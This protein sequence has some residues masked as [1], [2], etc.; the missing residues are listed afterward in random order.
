MGGDITYTYVS[1]NDYEVTLIIY[2]DC[3]GISVSTSPS[4]TFESASCG[5]NFNFN[6]PFI[7]INDVSQ[8]C[9]G[10]TTTCNGG[11]LPGV[12]QYVF[13]G[14]VTLT[15]CA[16]WI[17]HWNNG[18][19]NANITNLVSPST[20][21]L[22]IQTTLNNIVG[23]N[24]NSPQ[25]FN[26]PTPYLCVNNLAILSHGATDA[27]GDS[28]YYLMAQP[29]TTPGPPGVLIPYTA[30]HTVLQPVITTSGLTL[31]AETGQ[32]CF[33]PS[34]GQNV[35]ISVLIKEYRNGSLIGSLI[36]EMQ[37]KIDPGC[38]NSPPSTSGTPTCNGA[39][40]TPDPLTT[41]PTV[42][43]VDDNSLAMCPNTNVCFD[44]QFSDLDGDNILVTSNVL[45]A[46]PGAT[47]NVINNNTQNPIARVCWT[48]TQLDSGL[49]VLTILALDDGC[50][51]SV[52]Q[53]F[54]FDITVFDQPYAGLDETICENET[55]QLNATG[56][57]G[58]TWYYDDGIG[59]NLVP[60]GT[61]FSCNPCFNPI[62]MPLVTTSYYVESTLFAACQN[63]DTLEITVV[64]GYTLL[65]TQS[66]TNICNS[67]MVDFTTSPSV[68]GGYTYN[69]LSTLGN[70]LTTTLPDS[71]ALGTF[72]TTGADTVIVTVTNA[73]CLLTDTFFVNV[74][75]QPNISIT[76][77]N[78]LL[79]C[80]TTLPI[81]VNLGTAPTPNDFSFDWTFPT[82]LNN[83]TIQNPNA[84]P[85]QGITDYIVV[86]TDTV[87]NCFDTDT[88]EVRSCCIV[89]TVTFENAT[90]YDLNNGKI[91]ASAT[92]LNS[93]FTIEFHK[94]DIPFTLLQTSSGNSS[95]SLLY[96]EPGSYIVLLFDTIGCSFSDTLTITEPFPI[97][98][99]GVTPDTSICING[100]ATLYAMGSGA[101]PPINL[102]WDNGLVGNG[103]H[104]VNP[105]A[106]STTYTV[107]AQDYNL[108]ISPLQHV[109]VT[110]RDSIKIN[111]ISLTE[112]TICEGTTTT[113]LVDAIGGGTGLIYTW[114]GS[115]NTI[116]GATDTGAFTITPSFDGETFSVIVSDSC[117]TP[118]KTD[119]IMTDWANIVSPDYT[120]TNI[121]GCSDDL[122]FTPTFENITPNLGNTAS[123]TWD[124]G[125]GETYQW[126][127]AIPFNYHY[128][129]PGV[130]DVTLTVTDQTGCQWDTIIA[131][132]QIIAHDNPKADFLWNPNPT[133][134]LNA[135][136]TFTN[137]SI[138]NVFNQW[139][140][141]TNI[142][143]TDTVINPVFQFPQDKPGDYN[144][145]LITTNQAGCIDS[146]SKVV[147]IDD[148][149][150]FYIPTAF[151][152]DGDGLNDNFKV[153]G[154]GLD[155]SNF[156]MTVFN[157][158]GELVFESNNPDIGWDGTR[159]GSLVP[160]GVY[161]WKIDAKEAHSPI[162]HNKDGFITIVR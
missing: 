39:L 44:V 18:T 104:Q 32:M 89:P 70:T 101:T 42:T 63:T 74:A 20:R 7:Q 123:S 143:H 87:G 56:G 55:T 96:L 3:Y 94:N 38:S 107:Y 27:D 51:I 129:D 135:Q 83:A 71:I 85:T 64:P 60:V 12:Q 109:L 118:I 160:D 157:K 61:E 105:S 98:L 150:L 137:Q 116:I 100:W 30:G 65:S 140:F 58:Y 120:I 8:V 9:A 131:A 77:P 13:R 43:Q 95:D 48:P 33:T 78:T 110:L 69:W 147:I 117:Y 106:D 67:D 154:E 111:Q 26:P 54:I 97:V 134:Y 72:N 139:I 133:D 153:V 53:S 124:F 35:V 17:M 22:Y 138:D 16:D 15:P 14:I 122:L 141:I 130:Y 132:Y 115:N 99:S 121:E 108:C 23:A 145:T 128:P 113:I 142:Q 46:L 102:I 149:F 103:P 31:N 68:P 79:N 88:V 4:V 41:S 158:W 136:I 161:I 126:P 36:R 127:F 37:V 24:N 40:L 28:L 144:V 57:A 45:L 19:R 92:A 47:W 1:G 146:I 156:K 11:S 59:G 125:N 34:I 119:T 152:P 25:F 75:D 93:D 148:V 82:T 50:P 151:T 84:T 5:Q 73:N 62:I 114:Y 2:R 29:L 21:N 86:V 162:I 81:N 159:N 52:S 49:N 80:V 6:I 155:L 90:C 91:V 112:D 76:T 10:Q 66:D